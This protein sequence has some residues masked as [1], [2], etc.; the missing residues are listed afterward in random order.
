[1]KA[2]SY[3]GRANDETAL[4]CCECGTEFARSS[5]PPVAE[6]KP[7]EYEF[8]PLSAADRQQDWVTLAACRTLV[9]ADLVASRLQAAGI[10]TFLPDESLMQLTGWNFNT[11]GYVRVQIPPKDYDAAKELL[12]EIERGN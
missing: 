10:E 9:A 11:Y 4:N 1:M 2:C 5:E 12:G 3:C 8:A 7:P 6:S